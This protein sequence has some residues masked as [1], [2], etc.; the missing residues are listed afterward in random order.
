M[1]EIEKDLAEVISL[2]RKLDN[3]AGL[4]SPGQA[5]GLSQ[6]LEKNLI[7]S[8]H[9]KSRSYMKLP[10]YADPEAQAHEEAKKKA[11]KEDKN[12]IEMSS[13]CI[14]FTNLANAVIMNCGHGGICYD[15]GRSILESNWK[16]C[17]LCREPLLF[18]IELDLTNTFDNFIN[19]LTATYIELSDGSDDEQAEPEENKDIG[20]QSRAHQS[21][22]SAQESYNRE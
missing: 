14:C 11:M 10:T 7:K 5:K 12:F 13:C 22:S 2:P 9:K 16:L 18:V 17:H 6:A 20:G 8:G 21:S 15:C 19:V 4:S 1:V 3:L